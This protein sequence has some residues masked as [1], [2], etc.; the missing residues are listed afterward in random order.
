MI[1]N[2]LSKKYL[3]KPFV[4]IIYL[5]LSFCYEIEK[6]NAYTEIFQRN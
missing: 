3:A 6:M 5:W 1:F 4:D 2:T